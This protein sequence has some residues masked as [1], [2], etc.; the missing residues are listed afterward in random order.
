MAILDT[1]YASIANINL[2]LM[3]Y[4]GDEIMLADVPTII[5]LRWTYFRDNWEFIKP[6]LQGLVPSYYDPDFLNQQIIDFSTFINSERNGN[7]NINPFSDS[8]IVYKF[9]AIFDNIGVE[10]INLTNEETTILNNVIATVQNYSKN[11]FVQQKQNIINYRD[12]LAD[13]DGLTDATYNSTY[14]RSPV[15]GQTTATIVDINTMYTLQGSIK[16]ADFILSN[17]FAVDTAVD[18]FALARTNAN[19]PDINIGQYS[20][21]FLVKINYGENLE[22]LA[23][24]YLGSPDHW[25]DIAIANGLKPPYIDEI[26][27]S[28]L[29]LA[30]GN[31]NKINIA[32]TDSSGNPNLSNF[33]VNQSMFLQSQTQLMPDQRNVVNIE[34]IPVSGEIVLTLDGLPNLNLYRIADSAS[35]R[36]FAPGTTN[37]SFFIL[38]PS[39]SP[40]PDNRQEEVPWFLAKSADDEKRAKVDL[41]IG[42]NGDLNFTTNNDLQLSYGLANDIQAMQLKIITELGELDRHPTYGLV[43][44]VGKTNSD[45]TGIQSLIT[46]SLTNQVAADSRFDRIESLEVDYLVNQATNQGV[47]AIAISMT[48]RLAGGNTV[49]PISFTINRT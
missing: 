40:L 44:V 22:S 49:V 4:T 3:V 41:A 17:L 18:P 25:I 39:T 16:S 8:K 33:Y 45:I 34:V 37:S 21:G 24:R 48:V 32:A 43:S 26:G 13:I 35:V 29:L 11:D 28:L 31:G 10:D 36:I 7:P 19:N 38:I 46:E 14:S 30:N 27:T 12:Y 47:A 6:T 9:Y 2:W 23:N 20:S 5:P 1:A 15:P 42:A